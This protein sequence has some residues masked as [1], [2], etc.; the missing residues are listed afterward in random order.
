MKTTAIT[1]NKNTST[2]TMK[3]FEFQFMYNNKN[4]KKN[5]LYK[6]VAATRRLEVSQLLQLSNSNLTYQSDFCRDDTKLE[7][8]NAAEPARAVRVPTTT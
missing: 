5:N 7:A 8:A 4:N 1:L 2:V 6:W 3:E